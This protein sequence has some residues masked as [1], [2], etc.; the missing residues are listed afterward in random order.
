MSRKERM[1]IGGAEDGEALDS[2]AMLAYVYS[3]EGRWKEAEKLE[4]QVMETRRMKLGADHH[5]TLA[6]MANLASMFWKK[7]RWEEA[8]Q[9]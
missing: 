4:V 7:G 8:E 1:E 2:T 5:D 3:L 6:S 9:L